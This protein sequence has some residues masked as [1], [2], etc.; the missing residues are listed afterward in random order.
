MS[1]CCAGRRPRESFAR[2]AERLQF[3]DSL[4]QVESFSRGPEW[5][6]P[7]HWS[8]FCPPDPGKKKSVTVQLISGEPVTFGDSRR[9]PIERQSS[10]L[11]LPV[12]KR[13]P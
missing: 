2:R 6:G 5:K 13:S 9:G 4:E 11:R 10:R 12:T 7:I 8:A 3:F 1:C